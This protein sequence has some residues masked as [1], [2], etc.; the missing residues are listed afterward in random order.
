[1]HSPLF[2]DTAWSDTLTTLLLIA[3]SSKLLLYDTYDSNIKRIK[4]DRLKVLYM[5]LSN[6]AIYY[7]RNDK[8]VN[9]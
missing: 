8:G 3:M 2:I 6:I 1:M 4:L 9:S 5:V 7:R